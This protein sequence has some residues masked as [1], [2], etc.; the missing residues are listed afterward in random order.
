MTE[1]ARP[2]A[3]AAATGAGVTHYPVPPT[4]WA[5]EPRRHQ[6]IEASAGT[7]KTYL[8]ER[9]VVDLLVRGGASIDQVLLVTFTEKAT[10]ELRRRVRALVR[11]VA[12]APPGGA[13]G[14]E[15]PAWRIDGPT[16]AALRAALYGFDG[17]AI[18]TI[19]GFCHRVLQSN[20]FDGGR[21]F[22]QSQVASE[23]ALGDAFTASL[24]D[25]L[26]V[27]PDAR[28]L[29]EAWL[30]SG[31]RL[32]DIARALGEVTQLGGRLARPYCPD[33][34]DP[35]LAEL[36]AALD[37]L[38]VA[39][40]APALR[41]ARV[42]ANTANALARRAGIVAAAAERRRRGAP[43]AEVLDDLDDNVHELAEKL[44][45]HGGSSGTA[46][47]MSRVAA[48][49]AVAAG[50]ATS[51]Q[52]AVVARFLPA[53]RARL[54]RE[55]A[56]R[57]QFDFGDMLELVWRALSGPR[58]GELGARLRAHH[59]F[60]L[61]D[62]FQDT[63]DLQWS[64]FRRLYL[65][66]PGE[67]AWLSVVGDPKQAIY[68]FRGADVHTYLR[69]RREMIAAGA[70]ETRLDV[71]HRAG[72]ALVG[73]LDRV[74]ADA[75]FLEPF[76]SGGIEYAPV[77][78]AA[79]AGAALL[80]ASGRELAPL[81]ILHVADAAELDAAGLRARLAERITR[82][83][84]AMVAG[85]P[86]L[87]LRERAAG[88]PARERSVGPGDVFVLT[89]TTAESREM[90]DRLRRAGIACALFQQEGLLQ[91]EEAAEVRD[92]L[93]AIASPR[94]PSARLRAWQSRFFAVPLAELP[95]LAAAGES[96]ALVQR[97]FEWKALADRLDYEALFPRILDDT[98]IIEREIALAPGER[99]LTN[100]THLFELLLDEMLVARCD[101]VEL[102]RRL[103]R[104]I[105]ETVGSD[106]RNVQRL[107]SERDA[108][109]IMTI[110]RAKGLEAPVVF[111]FG[112]TGQ[113]P[114]R[115][116]QSF[117]RGD[118]R[119]VHVGRVRDQSI[120]DAIAA[121]ER[122]ESERLLYVGLTRASARLVVAAWPAGA[123]RPAR[124]S[125]AD[126]LVA[127]LLPLVGA[128]EAERLAAGVAVEETAPGPRGERAENDDDAPGRAAERA[129][130]ALRDWRPRAE[131][132]DPGEG[133]AALARALRVQRGPLT[134]SY[135]RLAQADG[136]SDGA[137]LP[138]DLGEPLS[139]T[140]DLPVELVV[141]GE[142]SGEVGATAEGAE[143]AAGLTA[144]EQAAGELAPG[145]LAAGELA[146]AGS[147]PSGRR[148]GIF[149]H[150]ALEWLA[151]D[152]VAG[153]DDFAA[154]AARDDVD[155]VFRQAA[156]R[157]DLDRAAVAWGKQ[158]A[159]RGLREPI[160]FGGGLVIP[161]V[162]RARRHQ[163]EVD[164]LFPMAD[165]SGSERALVRGA[166]DL[167]FEHGGR[168]YWLDWKSD[169]CPDYAPATLAAHVAAHYTLQAQIYSLALSRML[170]IAS[171]AEHEAR[172]G[173]LVYF[174]L[175]GGAA[176]VERPGFAALAERARDLGESLR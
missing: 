164:F 11:E 9:R 136:A 170:G 4:V 58:G 47:E 155:Q 25:T 72:P 51:L 142:V 143:G 50:A 69:A 86:P 172:F 44:A 13:T 76:F 132:V 151:M 174:F 161:G 176:H 79:G 148:V 93:A 91:T 10:A 74:L 35:A 171:A 152:D 92:L 84:G 133:A 8:L 75:P 120:A 88:G 39:R 21:P 45:G 121:E 40:L 27:E 167:V 32:D 71:C 98:R 36:G 106:E 166:I 175:R 78:A 57:G 144:G 2:L 125:L 55:K 126:L 103:G 118:E 65:E 89:R 24:R 7:G 112:G 43:L 108:V 63:D 168:V 139:V 41:S 128:S 129:I 15:D 46:A 131:V 82:D 147:P 163:R 109:Q 154:W 6:V 68:G 173:G 64:I 158:V 23:T 80:D 156:E 113:A 134:T 123:Q 48:A 130:A 138:F 62:E 1:A 5:M 102:V 16:R 67:G 87:R 66:A 153:G 101:L 42:H 61:I 22:R 19:H 31:R 30:G 146:I 3:P 59:P 141:D 105:E 122:G 127:R 116:V 160:D 159:W 14:E 137:V 104:W 56:E 85:A 52:A 17:A 12:S 34:L 157:Q 149:L 119:W 73:A 111:L 53:V 18:H 107:E 20:A 145:E 26:S 77:R 28:V 38:G 90:A 140:P 94:D 114:N 37:S 29:L 165:A 81:C 110:H 70:Q 169:A 97:L 115:P 54:E 96:H 135:T 150:E 60:A 117:H 100:F 124:G 49:A 95:G 99:A 33:Q 83:I 162:A